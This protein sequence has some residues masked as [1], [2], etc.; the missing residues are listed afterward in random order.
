MRNWIIARKIGFLR[1][2]CLLVKHHA[3]FYCPVQI[4][5]EFITEISNT[6]I[7]QNIL[8]PFF[9]LIMN[10][11]GFFLSYWTKRSCANNIC[12]KK[13]AAD[14][15]DLRK[16]PF[17]WG[18]FHFT[19]TCRASIFSL[20]RLITSHEAVFYSGG[21]CDIWSFSNL[22]P[23]CFLNFGQ[24]KLLKCAS[25]GVKFV[26]SIKMLKAEI[27]CHL[28]CLCKNKHWRVLQKIKMRYL[29]D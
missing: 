4:I 6:I 21:L 12:R 25:W 20:L 5:V 3:V 27:R 8:S 10:P 24:I 7:G 18:G 11:E 26:V 9:Y 19:C 28:L 22:S 14:S 23:G 17:I 16:G 2:L 29:F 13:Q 1:T 15:R